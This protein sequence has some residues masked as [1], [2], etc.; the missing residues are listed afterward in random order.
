MA[1][2]SDGCWGA[3]S[4]ARLSRR[5]LLTSLGFAGAGVAGAALIGCASG[6]SKVATPATGTQPALNALRRNRCL[7]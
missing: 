2:Y 6:T 3:R 5:R 4:G 7:P 1:E